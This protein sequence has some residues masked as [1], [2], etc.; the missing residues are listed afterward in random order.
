MRYKELVS[1]KLENLDNTISGVNSL[2]SQPN[3]SRQQFEA[4]Y[5]LV[6]SKIEEIQTLVNT[7][8]QD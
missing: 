4:W 2:L 7:E 8:H 5:N 1:K 6:K 3:L